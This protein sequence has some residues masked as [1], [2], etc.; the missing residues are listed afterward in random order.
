[1]EAS[2][3]KYNLDSSF[4]KLKA[5]CE[6]ENFKGWDPYDGLNSKLFQITPLKHWRF[7]RLAWIQAFKLNPINLRSFFLVPKQHNAKGIG[8]FLSGYCN[9][10]RIA[11]SG[12]FSFGS[13][14]KILEQIN[15]L[16]G[17][18]SEIK[19]SGY[20]GACWGY[21][22]DWQ[23]RVFF[24]PRFTPTVV[25][26]S[27]C[28]EALFNAYEITKNES[29]LSCALSSCDFIANDLNRTK[30][31][32]EQF[33]FSY[34]PLDQSC[35]Y[36]AS[37]LGAKL[38][39]IGY[40]HTKN[41]DWLDLSRMAT[42]TIINKQSSD[43]SWI[44]GEDKVQNWVDSFHTGFNL[45]CIW[46]VAK[47]TEEESFKDS[48]K[49][50]FEYY[51]KNFFSENKIP[52]YY[53]NKIYPIDIHSPAQLIVTLTSSNQLDMHKELAENVLK[54]TID[55]MQSSSG[56]FYYQI[57]KGVS[58]KISYMRWAQAWMFKAFTDYFKL[59]LITDKDHLNLRAEKL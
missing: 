38:L 33:I 20:S 12:N 24:Q 53:H 19:T 57:K 15:F 27:F 40:S 47:Y 31:D 23:N 56:Y 59:T 54:W 1:M 43:G 58:S 48:F 46:K 41:N 5:Y 16:A 3:L 14:L 21:N 25:A 37:L 18:L 32:D 7:A 49:K 26:T 55:N 50:G 8:L 13:K 2:K 42:K 34:S 17:L 51:L 29:H 10:Y 36:N 22:F 52:K 39:S 11:E 28:G 6:D 4:L 9:L 35:V 45:E 30:I 44:Y